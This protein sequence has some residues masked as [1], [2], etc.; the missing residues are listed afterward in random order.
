[1]NKLL[2]DNI[3]SLPQCLSWNFLQSCLA[4]FTGGKNCI[5]IN[6]LKYTFKERPMWQFFNC[7]STRC[8]ILLELYVCLF[9][10]LSWKI[11]GPC[12]LNLLPR[13]IQL[14]PEFLL[15]KSFER[16]FLGSRHFRPFVP[17]GIL[18]SVWYKRSASED[19][20]GLVASEPVEHTPAV[21][22]KHFHFSHSQWV[23]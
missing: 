9:V 2:T 10:R 8:N 22:S 1:M 23:F 4:Q 13:W 6:I 5:Y 18:R 17:L 21:K 3:S 7:F 20:G 16:I 15:L 12:P 19:R 11:H 14:T